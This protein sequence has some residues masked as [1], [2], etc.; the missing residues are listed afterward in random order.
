MEHPRRIARRRNPRNWCHQ[1]EKHSHH[2]RRGC[3]GHHSDWTSHVEVTQWFT[4]LSDA[5]LCSFQCD[6]CWLLM[7]LSVPKKCR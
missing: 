4:S 2:N 3:K 1:N 7:L 6:V 5:T